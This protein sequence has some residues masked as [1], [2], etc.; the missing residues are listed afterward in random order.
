MGYRYILEKYREFITAAGILIG[1]DI[2][3]HD[4]IDARDDTVMLSSDHH[5]V[6]SETTLQKKTFSAIKGVGFLGSD[7]LER[8]SNNCGRGALWHRSFRCL[9]RDK[10]QPIGKNP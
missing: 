9:F 3:V 2:G 4:I 6:R 10:L 5:A 8:F 1:A 7:L